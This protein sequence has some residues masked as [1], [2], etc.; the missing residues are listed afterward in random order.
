[1]KKI[2]LMTSLLSS[3]LILSPYAAAENTITQASN[4]PPG[5][6]GKGGAEFPQGLENKEKT[7]AGWSEGGKKGWN[8][9]FHKHQ[10]LH[11]PHHNDRDNN[12]DRDNNHDRN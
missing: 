3:I 2:I 9:T 12:R 6:Q 5:L 7:P 4:S 10:K 1:M 11:N 8:H